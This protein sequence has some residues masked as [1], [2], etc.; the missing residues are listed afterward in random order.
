MIPLF[1]SWLAV[2]GRREWLA[3]AVKPATV[4]ALVGLAGALVGG[5]VFSDKMMGDRSKNTKGF[6]NRYSYEFYHGK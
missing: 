1:A 4:I 6:D 3:K 2:E 5:M